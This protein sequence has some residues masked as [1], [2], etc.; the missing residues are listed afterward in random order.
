[1]DSNPHRELF[2]QEAQEILERLSHCLS[3]LEQT[4]EDEPMLREVY[5]ATHTL[6]SMAA[7]MNLRRTA[8]LCHSLESLLDRV[9]KESLPLTPSQ[10]DILFRSA[11]QLERLTRAA[12]GNEEWDE[13]KES[14]LEEA[15]HAAG[16]EAVTPGSR[17]DAGAPRVESRATAVQ[18]R[19]TAIRMNVRRLDN[20]INLTG[21][22]LIIRSRLRTLGAALNA[23]ALK[24]TIDQ[25]HRVSDSL[26]REVLQARMLP[27]GSVFDRF[28]AVVRDLARQCGKQVRLV[29][30]GHEIELDRT[31]LDDI[32]EPLIHLLRN[33]VF[34]GIES[35]ATRAELG[36]P[37]TGTI[38]LSGRREADRVVLEVD[39]DGKGI[40]VDEVRSVAVGRGFLS[41]DQAQALSPQEVV[42]LLFLPGLSTA[43]AVTEVS[44]RGVGLNIVRTRVEALR[45]SIE[46]KTTRGHGARFLLRFP[47]MLTIL[48]ALLV[49]VGE[50]LFAIPMVD[51]A[52]VIEI[53]R[54]DLE[55]TNILFTRNRAVPLVDLAQVLDLGASA[56]R[57]SRAFVLISSLTTRGPGFVVDQVAGQ[58]EIVIKPIDRVLNRIGGVS[59]ATILGDGRVVLI[60]DLQALV[61]EERIERVARTGDV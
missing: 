37:E 36:K 47:P 46:V 14:L 42:G 10:L 58:Q 40:D 48:A 28:A 45:G 27:V 21:E 44:G 1:M 31:I 17:S 9:L 51:I 22:L 11:D 35:P 49:R 43:S 59:G 52:E 53:D 2:V 55:T 18:A 5:R 56:G 50:E 39:D 29:V 12:E 6:K 16:T 54:A 61:R 20:L 34:Y 30:S 4:P 19:T 23:P 7:T 33:A 60:L 41:A 13:T 38:T 25:L 32:S 24:E 57:H 3:V 8:D 26:Q 15:L